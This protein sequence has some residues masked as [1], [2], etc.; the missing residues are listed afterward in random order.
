M[1]KN[2]LPVL[3]LLIMLVLSAA[4]GAASAQDGC[5]GRALAS[6]DSV[7][8]NLWL[9][10]ALLDEAVRQA[11]GALPAPPGAVVLESV[12]TG[13]NESE[14]QLLLGQSVF[15]VLDDA[16][17]EIYEAFA[18]TADAGIPEYFF[19]YQLKEIA[20]EYPRVGR[21]MGLW[22]RWIDRDVSV[23]ADLRI[24]E[25]A[26]GR[27][28]FDD[29]VRRSFSDRV[30]ASDL[31]VVESEL[32]GFGNAELEEAGWR[33]RLEEIVVVGSLAGMVAVYFANTGN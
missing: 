12:F 20:L 9:C 5:E 21:T 28:L 10:D 17:Y 6:A 32:Y 14:A 2:R 16:G 23:A 30:A 29:M 19:S 1:L 15:G 8:T 27:I 24:T 7:R 18:D 4:P 26:T 11:A 31:D 13:K 33:R 22:R 25:A 3:A